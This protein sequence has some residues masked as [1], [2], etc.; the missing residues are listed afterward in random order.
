MKS[1]VP[2]TAKMTRD[3]QQDDALWKIGNQVLYDLCRIHPWH[4]ADAAII[5]KV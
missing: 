4:V 2:L 1:P 5:A 3:A